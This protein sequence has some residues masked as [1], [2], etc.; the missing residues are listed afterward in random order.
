MQGVTRHKIRS[1][2][3]WRSGY[4]T[5]LSY[6]RIGYHCGRRGGYVTGLTGSRVGDCYRGFGCTGYV[7]V[8]K[9]GVVQWRIIYR[10]HNGGVQE[11]EQKGEVGVVVCNPN[12]IGGTCGS[13][14][15]TGVT[16]RR[17]GYPCIVGGNMSR[18]TGWR[19]RYLCRH[20]YVP[21]VGW[22]RIGNKG[23][24]GYGDMTRFSG[25]RIGY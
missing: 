2:R 20:R 8:T 6:R 5:G 17:I 22:K 24:Y 7:Q 13:G 12:I 14:Y 15:M 11:G 18:L 21:G 3:G 19:I 9:G 25:K 4:V 23:R 1:G 16:G 10:N